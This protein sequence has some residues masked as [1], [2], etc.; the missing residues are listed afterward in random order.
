MMALTHGLASVALVAI[1]TPAIR[2]TAGPPLLAAAFLGGLAPDLDLLAAHRKS[3]HYPVGYTL[4][5]ALLGSYYAVVPTVGGLL[6]T[7]AL[8]AAAVHTWSDVFAGSVE[9][10]PWNP[11]TERAVYN[12]ALGQWHRPRRWVRY[13]G[14]PEDFFLCAISATLAI[15]SS[16]TGPTA[17]ALLLWL[18][19]VAGTYTLARKRLGGLRGTLAPVVPERL[20]ALVPT[21]NV[22]TTDSGA[23]RLAF[24]RR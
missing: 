5:A 12:H 7:V 17:D 16:V 9:P 21:V 18:T 10:E 4:F 3:L 23:T 11:T 2:E 22:E 8:S 15:G 24:R 19:A 20:V 6:A 13:S 1:A 14:A